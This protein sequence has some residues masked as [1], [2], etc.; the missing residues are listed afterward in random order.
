MATIIGITSQ[1]GGVAKSTL[2]RALAVK[3]LNAKRTV[4]LADLDGQRTSIEWNNRRS[5]RK[6]TPN[7]DVRSFSNICEVLKN[8]DKQDFVIVDTPSNALGMK[9][10]KFEKRNERFVQTLALAKAVHLMVQPTGPSDD[11]I[12]PGISL[13]N[14]L[15][16][17]II[18][19][20]LYFALCRHS[21]N[22]QMITTQ[23]KIHDAGFNTL[24][25]VTY[26]HAAYTEAH[27][28][29]KSI[30]EDSR[31]AEH[32]SKHVND[33][34]ESVLKISETRKKSL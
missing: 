3:V 11:D 26:E 9:N 27:N 23:R 6:V 18:S 17:E 28:S 15:Q 33:L 25:G 31:I 32:K 1:K 14:E 29:G 5:E 4:L 21:T 7:I 2:A 12:G 10:N 34:I 19:E 22:T 20:N 13:F 16:N 8:I 24:K 30:I